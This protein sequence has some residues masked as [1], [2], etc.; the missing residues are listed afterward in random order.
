MSNCLGL[1]STSES[2]RIFTE[3][4]VLSLSIRMMAIKSLGENTFQGIWSQLESLGDEAPIDKMSDGEEPII[5]LWMYFDK[6]VDVEEHLRKILSSEMRKLSS[7]Y[8]DPKEVQNLELQIKKPLVPE[9]PSRGASSPKKEAS[10]NLT[11]PI[12]GRSPENLENLR[13]WS[14]HEEAK[15]NA[16]FRQV[17]K[18]KKKHACTHTIYS[19]LHVLDFYR[20]P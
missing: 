1:P 15:I 2:H 17:S 9:D 14:M 4:L 3:N 12:M 19:C 13:I 10:S 16:L 5:P 18:R 20:R 8:L 11:K 6:S 7:E